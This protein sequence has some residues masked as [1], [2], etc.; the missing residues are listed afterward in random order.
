MLP[1]RDLY[2]I[3]YL[4]SRAGKRVPSKG[5]GVSADIERLRAFRDPE[6][7]VYL[8]YNAAE[9]I[10][11]LNEAGWNDYTEADFTK[12]PADF[13]LEN[14]E[15]RVVVGDAIKA[16]EKA[17]AKFSR[18]DPLNRGIVQELWTQYL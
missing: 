9:I 18:A 14:D 16:A 8:A 7:E 15:E 17:L 11:E 5:F 4:C 12:L 2:A 10:A 6:G 13:V 1:L 3:G